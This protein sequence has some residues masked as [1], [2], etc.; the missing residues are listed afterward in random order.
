MSAAH[1]KNRQ[2]FA[3][4]FGSDSL[5][6]KLMATRIAVRLSE[7]A[8]GKG[9]CLLAEVLADVLGRLWP[10]IDFHG[11][12]AESAVEVART[13]ADSGGAPTEGIRVGWAP[14]YDFVIGVGTDPGTDTTRELQVG[15]NGWCVQLGKGAECGSDDNPVGPAFAA[16]LAA[17]QVFSACFRD[18]LDGY[19]ITPLQSWSSDLREL[20]GA[21]HLDVAPI[22]LKET[23][24]FGVGAVSH[25]FLWLLQHWPREVRG[26]LA[27]VDRDPYGGGNGQ[28]YAFMRR[29][30]V[31]LLK[32]NQMADRLRLN[33]SAEVTPFAQDLNM[34]CAMRGYESSLFRVIAGLD[35]EEARRHVALKFPLRTLNMW[36]S[37]MHIGAGQYVPGDGRGCLA[38][39]Y[40][41]PVEKLRDEVAEIY[42][43]T[44]LIPSVIRELLDSA[45]GLTGAEASLVASRF[46]LTPAQIEG[47]PLRSVLPIICATAHLSLAGDKAMVDV[48][49]AF[50]SLLS[51][52][53]G[54]MMLLRDV[55]S[56][57]AVSY[58]WTQHVLKPPSH[59][60]MQQQVTNALC[61]ACEVSKAVAH[62]CSD[63]ERTK[64]AETA[65]SAPEKSV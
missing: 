45:R 33:T 52:I 3:A 39:A 59:R 36:T 19:G 40:P 10:N 51:G 29:E 37:G 63:G 61:V 41:E 49:F 15:A 57:E 53:A 43:K 35:S 38:C 65:G 8:G 62:R 25:G 13:A 30:D 50:S 55:Q 23:H 27:L 20:F 48:P 17:A 14:P 7:F 4:L 11:A 28:R 9:E 34:Y 58:G 5:G 6:N 64:T 24:L 2:A 42:E 21:P 12:G 31:G 47:E 44:Y 56:S 54:F 18:A 60:M 32:V 1:D 22:D 26:R 46:G 16:A